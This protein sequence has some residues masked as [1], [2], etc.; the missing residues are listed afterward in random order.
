MRTQPSRYWNCFAEKL[1]PPLELHRR[2]IEQQVH[3]RRGLEE[4]AQRIGRSRRRFEKGVEIVVDRL[5]HLVEPL[6]VALEAFLV[7]L[8][9]AGQMRRDVGILDLVLRAGDDPHPGLAVFAR[10]ALDR[11][12]Q[13]H[14]VD[15]DDV[16]LDR[17]QHPG[18]SFSAHLAVDTIICQQSFT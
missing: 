14:I 6:A 13:D 12:K 9:A 16:R 3:V 5:D 1:V 8:A 7:L 18:R 15:A 4:L 17:L 2:R 11:R 10:I